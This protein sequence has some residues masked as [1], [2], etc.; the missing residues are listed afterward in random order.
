MSE[1]RPAESAG[2]SPENLSLVDEFRGQWDAAV[3]K[4]QSDAGHPRHVLPSLDEFLQRHPQIAAETRIELLLLDQYQR[5][6]LGHEIPAHDYMARFDFL[7]DAARL[8]LI[9]EELGYREERSAVPRDFAEQYR[10]QLSEAA[11]AEL[12]QE[13]QDVPATAADRIADDADRQ[14]VVPRPPIPRPARVGRYQV[15]DVLGQGAFGAVYLAID[16]ELQREVAVK[17]PHESRI[18]QAGGVDAL[19]AEARAVSRLDHPSI[20]PVYDISTTEDGRCCVVS[21]YIDGGDLNQRLT[22]PC[23]AV[24]AARLLAVVARAA[25]AAHRAGVIHRDIK[26]ANI[27]LDTTGQPFLADFGLA[28]QDADFGQGADFVGT[29]AWMSPEQ[30]RGEGHRVDARTDVYSLGVVLFEMLTG[31]R[32]Y[33]AWETEDLLAQIRNGET[34]PPRQ[35]DDRIPRA[36]DCICMKAMAHRAADRYSTALDLADEL[37]AFADEATAAS[38]SSATSAPTLPAMAAGSGSRYENTNSGQLDVWVDDLCPLPTVVPRGLRSF[39]SADAEFFLDLLPGARDRQGIPDSLRFWLTRIVGDGPRFAVGLVY[40]P[41]GCGKS[42]FVKAGL[43]PRVHQQMVCRYVE[44][45]AD[46][47]EQR[48]RVCLRELLTERDR[49]DSTAAAADRPEETLAQLLGEVRRQAQL[50]NRRILL[51]IDQFE[52][53]LHRTVG[54]DQAALLAALRQ[55]DGEHVQTVVMVRDDFW[56]AAT[57]FFRDLEIP[58]IDGKNAGP[59]DLF[60]RRHARRVLRMFGLAYG[61]LQPGGHLGHQRR[62]MRAA[63]DSLTENGMV[64]P[65]RIALF[66][67][68]LK[69]QEWNSASL[70][71]I[72]GASGIGL[73]FLERSFG[74]TA[75]APNRVFSQPAEKLLASLLPA[76]GEDIR[77]AARTTAELR[78]AAEVKTSAEF[79]DLLQILDQQLRLISPADPVSASDTATPSDSRTQRYQLTHDYLVPSVRQWVTQR[80]TLSFRSRLRGRFAERSEQ[81][82]QLPIRRLLPTAWEDIAFRCVTSPLDWNESQTR[83]MERSGRRVLLWLAGIGLTVLAAFWLGRELNGRQQAQSLSERIVNATTTE[84]PGILDEAVEFR[85]WLI[86]DLQQPVT[87]DEADRLTQRQLQ[88]RKLHWQLSSLRLRGRVADDLFDLVLSAPAQDIAAIAQIMDG[89]Y[90]FPVSPLWDVLNKRSETADRRLRAAVILARLDR[91]QRLWDA[92]APS[93]AGLLVDARTSEIDF[94]IDGLRPAAAPLSAHL[95]AYPGLNGYT[96]LQR[97]HAAR[98]LATFMEDDPAALTSLAIATEQIEFSELAPAVVRVAADNGAAVREVLNQPA[99]ER[100][101]VAARRTP[102]QRAVQRANINAL[103][104]Q[105][106]D[107]SPQMFQATADPTVRSYLIH[108]YAVAGG[109]PQRLLAWLGQDVGDDIRHALILAVGQI[110]KDRFPPEDFQTFLSLL[111]ETYRTHPDPGVHAAAEWALRR[112]D[113]HQWIART[114]AEL[115]TA[116]GSSDRAADNTQSPERRWHVTPMGLTMVAVDGPF[117]IQLGSDLTDPERFLNENQVWRHGGRSFDMAA[118]E[119]TV[120]L[121]A[122]FMKETGAV[123]TNNRMPEESGAAAQIEIPWNVAVW[124]CNWLNEKE[125]IPQSEWC[126]LPNPEG[127]YKSG[128]VIVENGMQKT[129]YRLPTHYEWE[130]AA[131]AGTTTSRYYGQGPEL[132]REYAWFGGNSQRVVRDVGQLKPNPW[133]LFDMLGNAYEWCIG[134]SSLKI[135]LEPQREQLV[136]NLFVPRRVR[137]GNLLEPER[138]Q[139]AVRRS[140]YRITVEGEAI[141]MR[142]VRT[143]QTHDLDPALLSGPP[144]G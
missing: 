37:D 99:D 69:G 31:Q 19:M 62:F 15:R 80:R 129:G 33:R 107:G 94:F 132:L 60:D 20:V 61:E 95:A 29:P 83:M 22:R 49:S 84:L 67:E 128:L 144:G 52:Q 39:D 10:D 5:W 27:L 38:D 76:P 43:L 121:F 75:S 8:N 59:I 41:S 51:I 3:K 104:I 143:T 88:R 32:P 101:A 74:E 96:D 137:G 111:E 26:P 9:L 141:G 73:A 53:W 139:R 65:V 112:H 24:E 40:G 48:L 140:F 16:P 63:V 126:Y 133:G 7:Q 131:K 34:R 100:S 47:T 36:I 1:H 55:C 44:A 125:G 122:Q 30:A 35:F 81:Y 124:F 106:G 71:R 109:S 46:E 127:A 4:L 136:V 113:R 92:A 23:S 2:S 78:Q 119:I 117:D 50:S 114:T 118:H 21:R 97:R 57:R 142:V 70:R 90:R 68:T 130:Y 13:V 17:V 123:L 58:L 11:F 134:R 79:R 105:L 102:R 86:E 82:G 25:H 18:A 135:E 56:M 108:H 14:P 42:S 45:T 116:A 54:G 77:G 110:A 87:I 66:A 85:P 98:A 72:G 91:T 28:L 120:D 103:K 6:T 89:R 93:L 64:S 12:L 138:F 115:A